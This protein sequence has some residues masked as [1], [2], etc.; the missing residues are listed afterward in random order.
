[1]QCKKYDIGGESSARSVKE[2]TWTAQPPT[3]TTIFSH[4]FLLTHLL[5]VGLY[6]CGTIRQTLKG[7]PDALKM[8][9]KGE[10]A[11]EKQNLVNRYMLLLTMVCWCALIQ[12]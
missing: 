7:F 2:T 6:G 3:Y 12:K 8:E 4:L 11:Q 1:M 5:L 10:E 9:G